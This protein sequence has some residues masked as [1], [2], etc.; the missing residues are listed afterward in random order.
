MLAS[1]STPKK[2]V[3]LFCVAD[4]LEIS[5]TEVRPDVCQVCVLSKVAAFVS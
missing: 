3:T 1:C 4:T 5:N 2:L